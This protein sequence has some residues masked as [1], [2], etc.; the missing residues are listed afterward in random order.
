MMVQNPGFGEDAQ[1]LIS[2]DDLTAWQEKSHY[3]R[4]KLGEGGRLVIPAA[5]RDALGIKPGDDM[6]L[7][8]RNGVLTVRPY[9]QAL[10]DIQKRV[11]EIAQGPGTSIDDFIEER[12]AEQRRTDDRF[13]R[14]HRDGDEVR[15]GTK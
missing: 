8:V 5:M 12:R 3:G 1:N 2:H 15:K 9:L 14:V 11:S 10:R 13:D 4:V 7:V 6:S